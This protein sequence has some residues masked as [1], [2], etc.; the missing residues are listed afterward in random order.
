MDLC[1][2]MKTQ[3]KK[4]NPQAKTVKD[5]LD[6]EDNLG[7]VGM[8]FVLVP[9][10]YCLCRQAPWVQVL[11]LQS[12]QLGDLG[13]FLTFPVPQFPHLQ[14]RDDSTNNLIRSSR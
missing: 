10:R 6:S 4:I 1:S 11:L 13:K 5:V 12:Y 8:A 14:N 3:T 9:K 2:H 7:A